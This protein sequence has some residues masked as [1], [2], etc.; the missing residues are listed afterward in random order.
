MPGW[1]IFAAVAFLLSIF[2]MAFNLAKQTGI[3]EQRMTQYEI[4]LKDKEND[5]EITSRPDDDANVLLERMR[6]END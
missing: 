5:Q 1:I 2:A 3:D 4:V 6:T